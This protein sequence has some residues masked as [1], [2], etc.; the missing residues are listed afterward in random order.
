MLHRICSVMMSIHYPT[1]HNYDDYTMRIFKIIIVI[2][3]AQQAKKNEWQMEWRVF[4]YSYLLLGKL[5]N[6]ER[7]NMFIFICLLLIDELMIGENIPVGSI[8]VMS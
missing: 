8:V 5:Y 6:N 1:V 4:F 3:L 2:I 7:E